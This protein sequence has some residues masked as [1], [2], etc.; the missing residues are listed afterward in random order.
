MSLGEPIYISTEKLY[1][2]CIPTLTLR[3]VPLG[4]EHW[5]TP[6][7]TRECNIKQEVSSVVRKSRAVPL[8]IVN[9]SVQLE[10]SF[11]IR[12]PVE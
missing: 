12:S 7:V 9:A 1:I 6:Q 8:R 5:L 11:S 2:F 4:E 10:R 3:K